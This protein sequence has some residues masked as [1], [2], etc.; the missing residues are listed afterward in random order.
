VSGLERKRSERMTSRSLEEAT[1][2]DERESP[3]TL[4][5]MMSNSTRIDGVIRIEGKMLHP[6]PRGVYGGDGLG[7]GPGAGMAWDARNIV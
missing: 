6:Y 5:L 4:R 3:Y 2:Q 7:A 1:T